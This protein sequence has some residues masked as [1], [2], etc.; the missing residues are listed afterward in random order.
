[1]EGVPNRIMQIDPA[2]NLL[3][4]ARRFGFTALSHSQGKEG[5]RQRKPLYVTSLQR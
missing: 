3:K 5:C 4:G 2:H 1:M